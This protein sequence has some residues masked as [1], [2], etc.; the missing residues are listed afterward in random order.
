MAIYCPDFC[1]IEHDP[2]RKYSM[3]T[4]KE[5]HKCRCVHQNWLLP[6]NYR[7]EIQQ[8]LLATLLLCNCWNWSVIRRTKK[9]R[10]RERER[11]RD[12]EKKES[13]R[14]SERERD[15]ETER[16][17]EL[18]KRTSSNTDVYRIRFKQSLLYV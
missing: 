9:E 15:R 17:F 11:D 12:R 13:E 2:K 5:H 8:L 1:N 6:E 14:E 16:E 4:M 7:H 3:R 10:E 18:K